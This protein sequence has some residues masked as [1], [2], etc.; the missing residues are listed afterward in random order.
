MFV[1]RRREG[2]SQVQAAERY[3]VSRFTYGQW[4]NDKIA[5]PDDSL[6]ELPRVCHLEFYEI[7]VLYRRRAGRSQREVAADLGY[8]KWWINQMEH[9]RVKCD[10]LIWHW[11]Q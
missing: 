7:C 4:E 8:C 11:E 5:L 10:A 9:G 1:L 6:A 3:L 2:R